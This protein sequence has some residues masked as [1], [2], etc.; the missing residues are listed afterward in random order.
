MRLILEF[1]VG[2][3]ESGLGGTI[4][5]AAASCDNNHAPDSS[6]PASTAVASA[7]AAVAPE[8]ARPPNAATGSAAAVQT[9][10]SVAA[11]S[12]AAGPCVWGPPWDWPAATPEKAAAALPVDRR[13]R[14]ARRAS[15]STVLGVR[16]GAGA[17]L[18]DASEIVFAEWAAIEPSAIAQI[19]FKWTLLSA[20]VAAAVNAVSGE[21]RESSQS[22]R[23]DVRACVSLINGSEFW[24]E[25]FD[26]GG[27][28]ASAA[29]VEG[30]LRQEED[31]GVL[32][33]T[34]D[35]IVWAGKPASEEE[36][37]EVEECDSSFSSG[38]D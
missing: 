8:A 15:T 38:Q 37:S 31:D 22:V 5:T 13:R 24:R 34:A 23:E 12:M 20:E 33:A 18:Q 9:G 26:S 4:Q 11:A 36:R 6:M 19:W 17:H 7:A 14:T 28:A 1:V 30:S 29:A 27:A 35:D 21:Y 32:A 3:F 16:E 25:T 10:N 2:A